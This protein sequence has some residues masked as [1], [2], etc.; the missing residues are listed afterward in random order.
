MPLFVF[1][2][3]RFPTIYWAPANDKNN[4]RK[5]Q[6]GREVDDFIKFIKKESTK[7]VKLGGKKPDEL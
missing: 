1:F 3:S 6:G 5:Y 4:P 2:F 7:P